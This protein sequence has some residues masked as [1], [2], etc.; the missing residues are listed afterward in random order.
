M[1]KWEYLTLKSK[2]NYGTTKFFINDQMQ[3][4]L[5]NGN[6]P[7]ILNQLGGQGWDLVGISDDDGAQV[8]IFKRMTDKT[9]KA[10]KP[11]TPA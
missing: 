11:T 3:P 1:Q 2:T 8:Y 9:A 4:A 7:V 6:F 10:P 5:K